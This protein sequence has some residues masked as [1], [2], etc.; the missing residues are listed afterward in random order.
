MLALGFIQLIG[1]VRDR[2][3]ALHRWLGRVYVAS[4]L[5]AAIGGLVFIATVGTI[6]GTP[7]DIGFGLYG[8]LMTIAA[9]QTYRHACEAARGAPRVGNPPLRTRDRV[10]AVPGWTTASG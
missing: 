1:P 10:V 2:F 9:V 6:G 4:S 7:M 3:P 8:V 5:L